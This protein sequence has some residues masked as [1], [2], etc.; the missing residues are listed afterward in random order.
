MVIGDDR[1]LFGIFD[2]HSSEKCSL[3]MAEKLPPIIMGEK[4]PLSDERLTEICV[5]LDREFINSGVHG[6][7]TGTFCILEHTAS[8]PKLTIC[9]VG[10]SRILIVRDGKLHFATQDHKP[11]NADERARIEKCGGMVRMNRVDGDLAVSRAFGDSSFKRHQDGADLRNQRVIAVP[12]ITR[13]TLNPEDFIVLACDGVFE[14]S[15]TNEEVAAHVSTTPAPKGDYGVVAATVCDTAVRR[16]SKDNIS[17]MICR[18]TDGSSL[19]PTHGE[20][21]FVPGP[22]YPRHH[23]QCKTAYARMAEVANSTLV[24]ALR[25][26]HELFVAYSNGS[27]SS[28]APINQLAFEMSDEV[29]INT[30]AAFWGAGPSKE[31]DIEY[32]ISLANSGR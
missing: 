2:G 3:F 22:P 27:L 18:L 30:E 26:R 28:M 14:G 6:G 29:D 4:L 20:A 25:R 8:P 5:E 24:D 12:D 19:V 16:G 32:F 15:F 9:N 10:D 13:H 11:Q 23:D 21:S 1:M 17:C 7:T 31:G